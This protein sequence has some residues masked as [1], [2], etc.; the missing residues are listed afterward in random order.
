[1]QLISLDQQNALFRL[2]IHFLG[3]KRQHIPNSG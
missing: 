1:M 3:V 2:Q